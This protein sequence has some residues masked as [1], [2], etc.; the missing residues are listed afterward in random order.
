M[1]STAH[2][3]Y[4]RQTLR[5]LISSQALDFCGRLLTRSKDGILTFREFNDTALE[6]VREQPDDAAIFLAALVA[7][8]MGIPDPDLDDL[9]SRSEPSRN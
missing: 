9:P 8:D 3:P 5:H 4:A 1:S 6:I 2:T 7:L